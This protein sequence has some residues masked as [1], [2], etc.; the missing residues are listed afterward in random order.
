MSAPPRPAFISEAAWAAL[1]WRDAQASAAAYGAGLAV[2][3]VLRGLV[4]AASP[5]VVA[6]GS[7][8]ALLWA[9][10]LRFG[11]S[12]LASS[13]PSTPLLGEHAVLCAAQTAVRAINAAA[14]ALDGRDAM[15]LLRASL[16][17]RLLSGVLASVGFFPCV[18]AA[19]SL[20]FAAHPLLMADAAH[21]LVGAARTQ[22]RAGMATARG[23]YTSCNHK[24]VV[25]VALV[26]A[27][28]MVSGAATRFFVG[29]LAMLALRS[30]QQRDAT[31]FAAAVEAAQKSTAGRAA[32]A[33]A[34]RV[35]LGP[36]RLS[37][38]AAMLSPRKGA[39]PPAKDA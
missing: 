33:A 38:L 22:M 2:V 21:P 13:A 12:L 18:A 7:A 26:A 10:M 23:A 11:R 1:Q 14:S 3:C 36:Q 31:G 17:L 16:L 5:T 8:N 20:L 27:V 24:R 35:S 37:Q 34:R 28:W 4:L 39:K 25:G 15:A 30:W 9:L 6:A 19:W 29:Y 32:S